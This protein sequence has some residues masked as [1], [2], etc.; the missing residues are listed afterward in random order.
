MDTTE[1]REWKYAGIM[2]T[3]TDTGVGKTVIAGALAASLRARG[4]DCGV[5]KPIQTGALTTPEGRV[6]VD[7]RF[8]ALA[9]GVSD[10]ADTVCP[11]LLDAPAAP[12]VAA[13]E[14]GQE[15]HILPILDAFDALATRHEL[16]I[17]EGAGGLAV[18]IVGKY[19]LAELVLELELPLLIVARAALG[20]INH[21][22]L[23]IHFAR[24]HGLKI[25]GVIINDYPAEPDLAERTAPALIE[26]LSGIPILALVPRIEDVDVDTANT[27]GL[28]DLFS[29]PTFS[30]RLISLLTVTEGE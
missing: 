10:P 25:L 20:T 9:A 23:T 2:V 26:R 29:E 14:A 18:P 19:L 4:I 21:T 3:G 15:I 24:H 12:S 13:A 11:V 16:M 28:A 27:R 22:L 8:L 30:D 5:M 6:S 7:A 1:G 17:V